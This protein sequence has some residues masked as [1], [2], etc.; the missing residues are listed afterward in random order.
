MAEPII[1]PELSRYALQPGARVRIL[2]AG[3]FHPNDGRQQPEPGWYL[4]AGIAANLTAAGPPWGDDY[5][6][7]Y[8]HQSLD[9]GKSGLP[10]PAAGWFSSLEWQEGDGLYMSG[11]RWTEAARNMIAATEY[12]YLSP[13]FTFAPDTGFVTRV[14]SVALTNTPALHGLTD[15]ARLP[16]E[17]PT[18]ARIRPLSLPPHVTNGEQQKSELRQAVQRLGSD[19]SR[20]AFM[21]AF[22]ALLGI[23]E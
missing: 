6:I 16:V 11:I 22:G 2:P 13:V 4:D 23:E 8:E 3:R 18:G 5:L 9:A 12:R 7:D 19:R 20:E 1:I 17:V 21:N 10:A 15:L 14:M